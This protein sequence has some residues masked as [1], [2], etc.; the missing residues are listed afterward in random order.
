VASLLKK[1]LPPLLMQRWTALPRLLTLPRMPLALLLTPLAPLLP[2]PPLAPPT[3][4]LVLLPTLPLVPPTPLL[5]PPTLLLAPSPTLP[6]PLLT[7]WLRPRSKGFTGAS[8][9]TETTGGR[10]R[11][12]PGEFSAGPGFTVTT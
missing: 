6:T 11:P 12:A 5:A 3:L 1:L 2:T 7:L 8:Q 9:Y 10:R 4:P